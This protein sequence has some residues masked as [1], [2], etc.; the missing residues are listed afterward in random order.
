MARPDFENLPAWSRPSSIYSKLSF[1]TT[2]N[3]KGSQLGRIVRERYYQ[4]PSPGIVGPL[5]AQ[6][7]KWG[8]PA[9]IICQ[10][11]AVNGYGQ[12]ETERSRRGMLPQ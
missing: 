7:L 5:N 2:T 4:G 12:R 1:S 6:S 10:M 8:I 3:R 9:R 11:E